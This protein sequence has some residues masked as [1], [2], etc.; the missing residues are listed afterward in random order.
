MAAT[1][2]RPRAIISSSTLD[3]A[4]LDPKVAS[5]GI[6]LVSN[7]VSRLTE[8]GFDATHIDCLRST[9]SPEALLDNTDLLVIMGGKDIHPALYGC[10][11]SQHTVTSSDDRGDRFEIALTQRAVASGRNVLGICRGMQVINVALG[12]T[13]I[14]H[15]EQ[16]GH[17][18]TVGQRSFVNHAVNFAPKTRIG[19][20]FAGSEIA[21]QSLHHQAVDILGN[22]LAVTARAKD[23][24]IEAIEFQDDNLVLGV[25]WHPEEGNS[26]RRQLQAIVGMFAAHHRVKSIRNQSGC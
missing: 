7:V 21:V 18:S 15:L 8:A 11:R 14:Q 25:Q 26:D 17:H 5:M 6:D 3:Y 23:G 16:N 4:D 22:N 10:E 9:S 24:T 1:K 2:R 20:L 13:L 19:S 12:G